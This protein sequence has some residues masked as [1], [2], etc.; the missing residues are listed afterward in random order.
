MDIPPIHVPVDRVVCMTMTQLG[1]FATL[2]SYDKVVATSNTQRTRNPEWLRRLND[3]RV[4]RIGMEPE[5]AK[6]PL[7]MTRRT[8]KPYLPD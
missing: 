1:S 6:V 4:S 5:V 3:G 8:G 2:D 7:M